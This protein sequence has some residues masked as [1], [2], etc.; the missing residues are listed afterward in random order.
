MVWK[1]DRLSRSLKSCLAAARAERRIGRRTPAARRIRTFVAT[2]APTCR[3]SEP[4]ER[5]RF[6]Q[7]R[8]AIS[9]LGGAQLAYAEG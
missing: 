1:L 9:Q 5:R 7:R 3:R 4:L 8:D 6:E 2:I